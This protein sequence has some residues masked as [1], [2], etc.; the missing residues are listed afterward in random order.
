MGQ[1]AAS[2]AD[3]LD[4]DMEKTVPTVIIMVSLTSSL[5]GLVFMSMGML[6]VTSI[7]NYMPYPGKVTIHSF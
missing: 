3:S 7:A 1:M 5:L 4:Q 2:I 6:R